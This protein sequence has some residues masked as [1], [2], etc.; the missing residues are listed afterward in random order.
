[1][2]K[3]TL[4]GALIML[5]PRMTTSRWNVAVALLALDFGLI[6][7]VATGTGHMPAVLDWLGSTAFVCGLQVLIAPS[8]RKPAIWSVLTYKGP[9]TR[10]T[11]SWMW[12]A[13][14]RSQWLSCCFAVPT[15]R[16][17]RVRG[18]PTG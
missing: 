11:D 3:V 10:R 2:L 5:F 15:N 13:Q 9:V 17:L 8:I 1:M 16:H 4:C 6:K 18:D 7:A 14:D 12:P